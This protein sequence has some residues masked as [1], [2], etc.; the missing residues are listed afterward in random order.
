MSH[1]NYGLRSICVFLL[2]SSKLFMHIILKEEV[3]QVILVPVNMTSET[4]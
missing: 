2:G 3:I 4:F 1:T